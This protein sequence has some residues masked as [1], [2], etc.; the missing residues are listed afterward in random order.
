MN[1]KPPQ[2]TLNLDLWM[3]SALSNSEGCLG[4]VLLETT[5]FLDSDKRYS[6]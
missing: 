3:K 6:F 2:L 5:L 4:A 1:V